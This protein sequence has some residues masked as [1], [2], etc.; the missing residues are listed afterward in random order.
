MDTLIA[1][2]KQAFRMMRQSPGFTVTAVSVLALGIAANIAIFSVVNTVLVAGGGEIIT[3]ND[4]STVTSQVLPPVSVSVFLNNGGVTAGAAATFEL[5]L[6]A[7]VPGQ[8]TTACTAGVPPGAAC[9]ISPT[10]V[11]APFNST[12]VVTLTTTAPTLARRQPE[13]RM[14]LIYAIL[15]P[16]LGAVILITGRGRS[17]R[18]LSA[19]LR[20]M[21]LLFFLAGCGGGS[22]PPRPVPTP[23]GTYTITVTVTN[24]TTN[25]QVTT[26]LTLIVR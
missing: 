8:I 14:L 25:F 17:K 7:P 22:G 23:P 15:M 6:N 9:L 20:G 2:L 12:V 10:P 18:S 21:A 4:T 26:P 13:S 11:T 5:L 24:T 1:D 19:T 3:M 16:F